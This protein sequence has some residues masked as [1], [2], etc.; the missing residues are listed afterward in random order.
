MLEKI[1]QLLLQPP[2]EEENISAELAATALMIELSRADNAIEVSETLKIL[3][4]AKKYFHLNP[5]TLDLFIEQAT[6]KTDKATSLYE[7]TDIINQSYSKQE[8]YSLICKLWQVAYA[9]GE[10]D[11]YEDHTIRK[12]AELIYVS[13]ADF[14]KAKH[15]TADAINL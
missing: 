10:V 6:H 1:K 13:H 4:I 7:F 11:R 9:D 5:D 2:T 8:K 14:I 3:D 12:I 15:E